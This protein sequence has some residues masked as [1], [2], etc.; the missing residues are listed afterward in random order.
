MLKI[1]YF[2]V[3]DSDLL[4]LSKGLNFVNEKYGKIVDINLINQDTLKDIGFMSVA[5]EEANSSNIFIIHLHGG[6]TSF[7]YYEEFL[8]LAEE[9]NIQTCIFDFSSDIRPD[10][11]KTSTVSIE[12]YKNI[13]KYIVYSGEENFKNLFLYLLNYYGIKKVEY[14]EPYSPPRFGIYH[15]KLDHLPDLRAYVDEF[16]D[17]DKPTIGIVFY[18]RDWVTR[19]TSYIDIFIN[20]FEKKGANVLACFESVGSSSEDIDKD[21]GWFFTNYFQLDGRTVIDCLVSLL[22]FSLCSTKIDE[23]SVESMERDSDDNY[24]RTW[25]FRKLGVPVIKV[26]NSYNEYS[27]WIESKQGLNPMDIIWSVALPE[28]DG[29]LI[30]IPVCTREISER[31]EVTGLKITKFIPIPER[32]GKAARLT[33]NWAKLSKKPNPE[34]KIAIIFHN[35]PPRNDQIA[36]A[37]GLDSTQSVANLLKILHDEGYKV[38]DVPQTGDQLM[39]M[40]LKSATND[41]RWNSEDEILERAIDTIDSS[42]VGDFFNYL[43]A[44]NKEKLTSDWGEAPG[45]VMVIKDNVLI[46]GIING[47]IFIGVQPRRGFLEDPAKIYHDPEVSPPWQYLGYYRWIRDIFKADAIMHIGKHGSLEWLPGKAIGLSENCYPDLA[48]L[49]L[50]NIYSYII[51]NPSEGTCAKRRSYAC[52]ID[53]LVPVMNNADSYG[54]MAE[55]EVLLKDYYD[56]KTMDVK[57]I[58]AQQKII[59]AKTAEAKLDTDLKVDEEEAFNDFDKFIDKLHGYISEVKDT[60]IRDGLHIMGHAPEDSALREMLI[61]LTRLANGSVPSLREAV[62]EIYNLDYED[63]LANRG[64]TNPLSGKPNAILLDEINLKI[65]ELINKYESLN[66]SSDMAVAEKAIREVFDHDSKKIYEVLKYISLTLLDKLARTT[67]ENDACI[68]ALSGCFV[69]PGPSGAPTR[70]CADILP[71]GRNFYSIDPQAVPSRAAF[72]TGSKLADELIERYLKEEGTYPESIGMI[73]WGGGVMRTKGDD[74]GEIFNLIGVKP[75]WEDKSG[76]VKGFEVIPLNELGRPRIDF[77]IREGGLRDAFPNI[78]FLINNAVEKVIELDEP[79]EMNFV[80]KHFKETYANCVEKKIKPEESKGMACARVFGSKPGTYGAGVSD[81]IDS[82]AW[83]D[84][85]D[86][87]EVYVTWGAYAYSEKEFGKFMPEVFKE[88][89]KKTQ[90]VVKNEDT[91]EYDFLD[92]DDFYSYQGGMIA[93]VRYFSGKDPQAYSCDT[94]DPDR[95]KVRTVKEEAKH[96]FRARVL[97]PKWIESMKKH[98]FKGAG[99]FSRMVDIAFGWDATGNTMEDWMYDA[100]AQTYALDKGMQD[101]FKEHNPYALH[102]IAERLLEAIERNMWNTT[103]E[104]K[105]NLRE[106]MLE[107]EGDLE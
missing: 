66:Y 3:I 13:F 82:Q 106:I 54:M 8:K 64:K 99:D 21:M 9:K 18:Q 28:F 102:N 56:V 77:T 31:D 43:P 26:V 50:P 38:D 4:P 90:I 84:D 34:K 44:E 80:R 72:K 70:G 85:K 36:S 83:T 22:L 63:I 7:P 29:D 39:G 53:H 17:P 25:F 2:T 24:K 58:P 1:T 96:I 65:S 42:K 46:P 105:E 107:I 93:A 49:D 14:N 30:T 19:N 95:V 101:F 37:F 87:A 32:M 6:E 40:L 74:I 104:M 15:P 86:F 92:G 68:K 76:R 78:I 79:D 88:R 57:K 41:L 62:A 97:N 47:N 60:L 23:N 33:I 16:I 91:R 11:I 100:L 89:L 71:T 55:I 103:E 52:I 51:N 27:D 12:A 48:I 61:A 45:K 20:E 98:G 75:V 5:R 10:L 73:I 67:E 81:L 94:S 35:Y 59:W 69:P